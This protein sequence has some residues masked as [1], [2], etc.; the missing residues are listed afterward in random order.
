MRARSQSILSWALALGALAAPVPARAQATEAKPETSTPRDGQ[1]DFDFLIGRWKYHLKRLE[2]P[3]T[4]ST[5]WL[6]FEGTGE[7][8][9]IWDG[10]AQIDTISADG[11]TGNVQGLTLRLYDPKAHQWSLHWANR[12][13][14]V[15]APPPTVG[16][17]DEK[18]GRGE[19]FD[20]E[21]YN[22]RMILVRYVWKDITPHSARFEQSFSEDGGRTWEL[23]WITTQERIDK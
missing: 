4:G 1:R 13:N 15:L 14:G 16:S 3:L 19:F 5:K 12:K 8:R 2:K 18:N 23:N 21:S 9:P 11:P 7:C 17:F 20:H 10:D 22:G 6:E